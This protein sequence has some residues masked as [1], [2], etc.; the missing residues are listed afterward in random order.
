MP[1]IEFDTKFQ[2]LCQKMVEIAFEFVNFNKKEVD[3]IYVFGSLEADVIAYE[4]MYRINGK[5]TAVHE[6][7]RESKKKY[8]LS[9]ERVISLLRQGSG[10]LK[11]VRFLFKQ[12][13][14]E[15]PT[16]FKM[17]YYPKSG[18][19]DNDISYKLHYSKHKEWTASDIFDQWVEEIRKSGK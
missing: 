6:L 16:L 4:L 9:D 14:R 18:K 13:K 12:D 1:T 5:L 8:D 15:V 17:V 2:D 11:E 7:N 10:Y 3:T 19:F